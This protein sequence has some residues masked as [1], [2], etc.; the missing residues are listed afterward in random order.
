MFTPLEQ[1]EIFHLAFLREFVRRVKP[2][3]YALKGGCN[4]RF[5]SRS[6]RYSEDMDLDAKGLEVFKLRDIVMAVLESGAFAASLRPYHIDR[7]VPPNLASAKQTETTQR[8]KVHLITSA[9]IDLFTKIEF[10]RRAAGGEVEVS[11][12][13]SALLHRYRQPPL[14]LAHYTA[15][16]AVRQKIGALAG[17]AATQ[18]RDAFDLFTLSSQVGPD[19]LARIQ[20]NIPAAKRE[21][22]E[23]ALFSIA[24][25]RFRDTVVSYLDPEEAPAYA[26]RQMWEHLQLKV[27][28]MIGKGR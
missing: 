21:A 25:E 22:A 3:A 8:F 20:K 9:G 1:R 19:E 16:A 6:Q 26:N 4:L 11:P 7:L 27:A 15:G 28:E 24:F 5:F 12:V 13:D 18:A 17:R 23:R 2:G 14:I 10:S